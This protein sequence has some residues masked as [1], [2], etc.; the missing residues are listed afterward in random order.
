MNIN[1]YK[2]AVLGDIRVEADVNISDPTSE[3]IKYAT[4]LLETAEEFEDFIETYF[5]ATGNRNKKMQ[6]D[7]FAYDEAD[8][9]CILAITD[10]TNSDEL[11]SINNGDIE[12][13][14]GRLETYVVHA[15]NG[16]IRTRCEESSEGYGFARTIED[17]IDRISKFKFYILTDKILSDR[18]KTIKTKPIEG[19]KC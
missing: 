5:E 18:V 1:E 4:G 12:R 10:F 14:Y 7:G 6:I 9:S 11:T 17:R 15:L 16:F 19:K 2:E 8:E 3:F 13:L